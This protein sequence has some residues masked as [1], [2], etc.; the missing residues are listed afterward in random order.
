[1][2]C[3]IL[4]ITSQGDSANEYKTKHDLKMDVF[5]IYHV[6][7]LDNEGNGVYQKSGKE[8][9]LYKIGTGWMVNKKYSV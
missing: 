9:F 2:P 5:G 6:K 3:S 8:S 4:S 7:F 1:M